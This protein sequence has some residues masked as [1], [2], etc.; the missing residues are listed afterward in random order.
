MILRDSDGVYDMAQ[1]P[2][3]AYDE[4]KHVWYSDLL[5]RSVVASY[6]RGIRYVALNEF[7]LQVWTLTESANGQVRWMM[8]HQGNLGPY[9]LKLRKLWEPRVSWKPVENKKTLVSLFE[10]C[11]M[12][13]FIYG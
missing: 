5:N 8:A 1:L 3:K 6:E 4:N 13:E 11:K 7:Q 12:E 10:P 9:D 2:G